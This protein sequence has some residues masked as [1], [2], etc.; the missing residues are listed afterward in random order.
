MGDTPHL[1]SISA[2]RGATCEWAEW[3]EGDIA[4]QLFLGSKPPSQGTCRGQFP[5][6]LESPRASTV[7]TV[8][9]RLTAPGRLVSTFMGLEH[10]IHSS[11]RRPISS[12]DEAPKET[13][14]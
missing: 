11:V 2:R 9:P 6:N 10:N 7:N 8:N 3:N 14:R 1:T 12:L 5:G 13:R 4:M